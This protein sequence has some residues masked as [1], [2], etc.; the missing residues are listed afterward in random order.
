MLGNQ[1]NHEGRYHALS[2]RI[3]ITLGTRID[4]TIVA[5]SSTAAPRPNPID[6]K[7]AISPRAKPPNTATMIN[8]APV[9]MLAV[10]LSPNATESSADFVSSYFSLILLNMN[11]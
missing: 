4:L 5:S 1:F 11:T 2:P 3:F 6:W 8:A 10:V 9:I 7:N